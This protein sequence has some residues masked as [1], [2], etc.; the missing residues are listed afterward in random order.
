MVHKIDFAINYSSRIIKRKTRESRMYLKDSSKKAIYHLSPILECFGKMRFVKLSLNRI[1]NSDI[2]VMKNLV[3]ILKKYRK[4]KG[5]AE[6]EP[7]CSP[8]AIRN[9][10]PN[11][12]KRQLFIEVTVISNYDPKTG[13]QR[14]VRAQLAGLLGK[15]PAGYEVEPVYLAY[16]RKRPYFRYA[17][18][19]KHEILG[20]HEFEPEEEIVPFSGDVFYCGELNRGSVIH[21]FRNGVY[22][23]LRKTGVS[24]NFLIH[25]L[26]PITRSEFFER[27]ASEDHS[28]WMRAIARSADRLICVSRA[29]RDDVVAWMREHY[30]AGLDNVR[31][32]VVHHGADIASSMPSMEIERGAIEAMAMMGRRKTFLMVGTMEP[33]KGYS[34]TVRAFERLWRKGHDVN[35]VIVGKEG[36]DMEA[37][38]SRILA[39]TEIDRRLFWLREISDE[40]L[41][42]LYSMSTCLI[43]ASEGEGFGLPLIEAAQHGLPI[44]ARD[45]PVFREVADGSAFFFSGLKPT[46][47]AAATEEWIKLFDSGKHPKP[48]T[49]RWLTWEESVHALANILTA[50]EL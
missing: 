49:M 30:P 43:A 25:D 3:K 20:R 26:L 27:K 14:V 37:V 2:Q 29:V 28:R 9:S 15:M 31:I 13:I 17:K 46:D 42:K 38:I 12:R 44:I 32:E 16:D 10:G 48:D 35:L 39:N 22:E 33:R 18:K 41:E 4:E 50:E 8:E 23:D 7:R 47:L 1:I 21:A 5:T 40:F 34:Q 24:I 36:W 6:D 11:P 45:I 19:Y